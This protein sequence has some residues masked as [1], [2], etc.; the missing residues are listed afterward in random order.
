MTRS[1]PHAEPRTLLL[2]GMMGAGKTAVGR[3][4]AERLGRVFI[5]TDAAIEAVR[6]ES[7]EQIFARAGEAEF[8]KLE[9]EALAGLPELAAVVALGGGAV[10]AAENRALLRGKGTLI[11]LQAEP[12]TLLERIEPDASRPLLAGLSGS[13]RL[14]RLSELCRARAPSYAHADLRVRTDGRTTEQ[15]CAAL[16]ESL[17]WANSGEAAPASGRGGEEVE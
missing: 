12:R 6:G 8:R 14:A 5:D 3:L 4:L 11:W 16:L 13:E 10:S 1:A 9:R 17:G 2:A 15:V 7:V